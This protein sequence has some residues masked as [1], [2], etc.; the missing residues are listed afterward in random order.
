MAKFKL[1]AFGKKIS[2]RMSSV[3]YRETRFGT[4]MA[5]F[6]APSNPRTPAQQKVRSDFQKATTQWRTLTSTQ[7]KQWKAYAATQLVTQKI[8]TQLYKSMGFNAFVKLAAKW[9]AVNNTGTAPA[10]PPAAPFTGDAISVS[11]NSEAAGTILFTATAANATNV[12]T[13]LLVQRV[14]GPN[15]DPVDEA[16]KVAKYNK[17]TAG[18]GLSTTVS[19][20]PGYYA[21]GYQFVN[22]ATG[23]TTSPVFQAAVIGPVGFTVSSSD[24]KKKAA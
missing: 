22:T 19:V 24:T 15:S 10:T 1:A 17:F 11:A 7:V 8:T 6:E 14:S 4:E 3:V 12:T 5:E 13:A 9:Y 23:Q 21:V 16:Y 20:L 18:V 2:G